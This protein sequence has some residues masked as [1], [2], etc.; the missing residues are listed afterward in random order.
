[1]TDTTHVAVLR[2][3]RCGHVVA[4][5]TPERAAV[6]YRRLVEINRPGWRVAIEPNTATV[7]EDFM[8]GPCTE[9]RTR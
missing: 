6:L 9:C 8:K 7:Y 2:N 4:I 5:V 3:L 1:M